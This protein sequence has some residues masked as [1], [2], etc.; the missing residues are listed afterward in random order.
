MLYVP[1]VQ[2]IVLV[3]VIV[4]VV[5]VVVVVVFLP[6][7]VYVAQ[8]APCLPSPLQRM[9]QGFGLPCFPL[10]PQ[11]PAHLGGYDG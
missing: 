2:Q 10:R 4:V 9:G 6:R 7:P 5:V 3:I 8:P 1:G 11:L